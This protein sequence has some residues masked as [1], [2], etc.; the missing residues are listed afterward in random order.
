MM[1]TKDR[2]DLKNRTGLK[3]LLSDIIMGLENIVYNSIS[4]LLQQIV[5]LPKILYS[6]ISDLKTRIILKKI[7]HILKDD[8]IPLL[9]TAYA[10]DFIQ[11]YAEAYLKKSPNPNL[12]S[13]KSISPSC[14]TLI[15][16]QNYT[17]AQHH[18]NAPNHTK[19]LPLKI[20]SHF[21]NIKKA[22][23]LIFCYTE[24]RSKILGLN[25]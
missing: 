15:P 2:T 1:K 4:H 14:T 24:T 11:K 20:F 3:K 8:L 5:A 10:K 9:L 22:F 25:N 23:Y 21:N 18:T 13:T 6:T 19:S 17:N 7:G 12:L 16:T